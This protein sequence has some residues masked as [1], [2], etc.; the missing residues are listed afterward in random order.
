MSNARGRPSTHAGVARRGASATWTVPTTVGEKSP[1][2]TAVQVSE[3][4]PLE[5]TCQETPREGWPVFT[6][7]V[8]TWFCKRG[9]ATLSVA[10]VVD[11]KAS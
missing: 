3:G 9:Q 6:F 4:R 1:S 11:V 2:L 8:N 10:M 5:A 7:D